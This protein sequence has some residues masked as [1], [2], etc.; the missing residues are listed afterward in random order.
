MECL[1]LTNASGG[2]NLSYSTGD[3][4]LIKDHINLTGENPLIGPNDDSLGLRFPDMV[5]VY[6]REL[7]AIAENHARQTGIPVCRGIYAGLKGPSLETP[8]EMRFLHTIGADAVGFSTVME[9]IA[10][11][12]AKMRILGIS[13]ITNINDPDHPEAATMDSVLTVA[14]KATGQINTVIEA[15]IDQL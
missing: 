3:I 8:A 9:A 14:R 2:L 7:T 15:V 6:D 5:N 12:H 1:I 11:V 4:M 13:T 10:G